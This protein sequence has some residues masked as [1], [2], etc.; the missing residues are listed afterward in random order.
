MCEAES[1]KQK[2]NKI[3]MFPGMSCRLLGAV[4]LTGGLYWSWG[5]MDVSVITELKRK[6]VSTVPNI[7]ETKTHENQ[8]PDV[9]GER[10]PKLAFPKH[11]RK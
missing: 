7:R 1:G 11:G 5:H 4:L 9:K 6:P 10:F 2:N 8:V 3:L